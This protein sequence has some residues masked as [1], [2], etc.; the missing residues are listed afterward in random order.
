MNGII[1][2]GRGKDEWRKGGMRGNTTKAT[3]IY[4]QSTILKTQYKFQN[5]SACEIYI[6]ALLL[7]FGPL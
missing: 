6:Y 3:V 4:R 5:Y 2:G 1:E 7:C